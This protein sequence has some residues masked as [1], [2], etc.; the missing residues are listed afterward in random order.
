LIL[1]E[2]NQE[3]LRHKLKETSWEEDKRRPCQ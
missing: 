1:I 2:H 3:N